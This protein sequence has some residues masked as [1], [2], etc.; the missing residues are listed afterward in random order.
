MGERFK[1]EFSEEKS[2]MYNY[3]LEIESN[4]TIG[5]LIIEQKKKKKTIL[6]K[7][8]DEN[9]RNTTINTENEKEKCACDIRMSYMLPCDFWYV[10]IKNT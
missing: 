4:S 1:N 10:D 9:V 3:S 5:N 6:K 2:K 7:A 8:R